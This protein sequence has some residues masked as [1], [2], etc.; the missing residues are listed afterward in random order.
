MPLTTHA[1]LWVFIYFDSCSPFIFYV[2][3]SDYFLRV[4]SSNALQYVP[5]A[6]SK[7]ANQ[8]PAMEEIRA[9]TRVY[10]FIGVVSATL[11]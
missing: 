3:E 10:D 8:K 1:C 2:I 4:E 5:V 7:L 11:L 9:L 6:H